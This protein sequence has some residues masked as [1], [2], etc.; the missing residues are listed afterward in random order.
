MMNRRTIRVVALLL[1]LSAGVVCVLGYN[2]VDNT[3]IRQPRHQ[4][5]G[6][7]DDLTTG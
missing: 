6:L 7:D 1:A 5:D 4:R 3:N 2:F